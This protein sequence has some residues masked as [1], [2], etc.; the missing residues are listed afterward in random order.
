M[1]SSYIV[2]STDKS[3]RLALTHWLFSQVLGKYMG[4]LS[5]ATN[6]VLTSHRRE[7]FNV[8]RNSLVT[9]P[10]LSIPLQAFPEGLLAW[11]SVEWQLV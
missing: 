4:H 8:L 3:L 9:T 6:I 2:K 5:E 11:A 7:V 10:C 1:S